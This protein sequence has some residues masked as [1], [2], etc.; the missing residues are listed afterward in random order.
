MLIPNYFDSLKNGIILIS[1]VPKIQ[2]KVTK[3]TKF[4]R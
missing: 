3:I 4:M 2:T 1:F